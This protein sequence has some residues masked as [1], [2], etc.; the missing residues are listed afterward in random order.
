[1]IEYLGRQL[2]SIEANL[3]EEEFA[4][5]KQF[6]LTVLDFAYAE[7]R[8][9]HLNDVQVVIAFNRIVETMWKILLR[10]FEASCNVQITE[11]AAEAT[12]SMEGYI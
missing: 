9:L 8:K 5:C 11:K 7:Q 3:S 2:E 1:A 10:K 6:A 12:G 4:A